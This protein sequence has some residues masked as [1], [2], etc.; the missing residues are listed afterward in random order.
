MRT[1]P[2]AIPRTIDLKI[3]GILIG[4]TKVKITMPMRKAPSDL[5][6]FKYGTVSISALMCGTIKGATS[7]AE[8]TAMIA[9]SVK[10]SIGALTRFLIAT[11]FNKI[12]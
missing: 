11:V 6:S 10:I 1:N 9:G 3:I 2:P 7:E 4:A 8:R 5:W 12:C